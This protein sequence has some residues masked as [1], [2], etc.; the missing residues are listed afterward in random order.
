M[1]E[2][3]GAP[4]PAWPRVAIPIA[5]E[6][7]GAWRR[8]G[9]IPHRLFFLAGMIQLA[10]ASLWWLAV[11]LAR[12]FPGWPAPPGSV[13]QTAVHA[14]L[15][16]DGFAPLFMFGFLFTAGPR[17][18]EV[19]PPRA[20]S[21]RSPAL[22]AIAGA[23]ALVPAQLGDPSLMRAAAGVYGLAWL[24]LCALFLE[25]VLASRARDKVHAIVVLAALAT[26]ASTVLAF[27][28]LGSGAHPWIRD[29]GLWCFLVPVFSTVCHRMIPF[30]T[31]DALATR[32]LFQPR[33]MLAVMTGAPVVHGLLQAAGFSAATWLVDLP[34]AGLMGLLLVRWRHAQALGP[35]MLSMLY[36]GFC[37]YA[38]AL[39]LFAAQSLLAALGHSA[40]GLA[41]LHAL[42]IGFCGSLLM[43][44]VTR[45]VLGRSGRTVAGDTWTARL[46]LLLQLATLARVAAEIVPG[47][48]AMLAAIVLWCASLVPWCARYAPVCWRPRSDRRA[49]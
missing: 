29:I 28:F 33:W 40:L 12:A 8:L 42:A 14:L 5:T 35:R 25:L 18:L 4:R 39:S 24:W 10:L 16:I 27:T 34:A 32:P 41:P 13:P 43:A 11:Q 20:S 2:V 1:P 7:L 23:L 21:W 37:W 6:P 47:R 22:L 45:V 17:W 36:A 31:A 19:G 38:I 9:T 49:G 26:G 30:F 3:T 48:F 44:M 15:M 46:F